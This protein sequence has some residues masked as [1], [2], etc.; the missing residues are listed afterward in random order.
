VSLTYGQRALNHADPTLT[1]TLYGAH[2][3]NQNV[4]AVDSLDD[5]IDLLGSLYVT[6][7]EWVPL[8]AA[9]AIL[10]AREACG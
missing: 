10:S 8:Y 7:D 2:L 4:A 1:A 5:L 3:P 6:L 9:S